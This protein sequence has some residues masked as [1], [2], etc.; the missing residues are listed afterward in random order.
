IEVSDALVVFLAFFQNKDPH[1]LARQNH[2]FES[3]RKLVDIEHF[4]SAK[5]RD[6]IQ[7]KVIGDDHSF[8]LHAKLDQL[9]IDLLNGRKIRFYYLNIELA[10]IAKPL[11]HVE[12]AASALTFRRIRRI[13]DLLEFC[14]NE[15]WNNERA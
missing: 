10:V 5:L 14:E 6:F 8:E 15:I 1:R 13:G 4:H 2:G 7:V 12:P 9:E 3:V 11:E